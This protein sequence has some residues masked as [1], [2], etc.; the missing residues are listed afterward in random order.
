MFWEAWAVWHW[1]M[2][3]VWKRWIWWMQG[4]VARRQL[5]TLRNFWLGMVYPLAQKSSPSYQSQSSRFSQSPLLVPSISLATSICLQGFFYSIPFYSLV[6]L[7]VYGITPSGSLRFPLC[8]VSKS[9]W[10]VKYHDAISEESSNGCA[11]NFHLKFLAVV[12]FWDL[13][14]IAQRKV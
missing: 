2:W 5:K 4:Y 8:K 7:I 6:A 13:L 3:P 1:Q 12:I 14:F 11:A 9:W 10:H